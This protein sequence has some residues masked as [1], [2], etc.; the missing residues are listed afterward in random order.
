[1]PTET[2]SSVAIAGC[3]EAAYRLWSERYRGENVREAVGAAVD[4]ALSR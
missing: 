4:L 3:T 1:M 2:A